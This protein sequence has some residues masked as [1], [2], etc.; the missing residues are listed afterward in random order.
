MRMERKVT[1]STQ[2]TYLK[3]GR[4]A[5]VRDGRG[6]SREDVVK[7]PAPGVATQQDIEF[8]D[9]SYKV[10]G[11]QKKK[12]TRLR[13]NIWKKPKKTALMFFH[14][15]TFTRSGPSKKKL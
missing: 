11:N 10:A 2:V 15:L 7:N 9:D 8:I 6:E 5:P 3:D 14:S 4:T 1:W 13:R 12:Q